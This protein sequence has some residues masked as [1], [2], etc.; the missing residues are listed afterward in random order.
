MRIAKYLFLLFLLI[1]MAICV[2]ILTQSPNF[3]ITQSQIIPNSK[4][5]TF[6]YVNNFYTW[7]NWYESTETATVDSTKIEWNALKSIEKTESF[8][9]DSITYKIKDENFTGIYTFS[10]KT[11]DNNET[12]VIWKVLG[13]MSTKWKF[14]TFLHGGIDNLL[15]PEMS[16]SLTNLMASLNK[17]FNLHTITTDGIV[18]HNETYYISVQDTTS[19]SEFDKTRTQHIEK[20]TERLHLYH[21]DKSNAPFVIFKTWNTQ[22]QQTIYETC[23]PVST[24][25]S[26]AKMLNV[27]YLPK[28][29]AVK[30]TLK[31]NYNYRKKAW[32]STF[33]NLKNS[34]HKEFYEGKYIEIY[35]NSDK[36]TP[37]NN[38]TEIYIPVYFQERK[39]A[40]AN[41]TNIIE[42]TEKRSYKKMA[43]D[44]IQR[45][46]TNEELS[47][48]VNDSL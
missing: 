47:K 48:I 43:T 32:D 19:F 38:V 26:I 1:A 27:K 14:W 7:H 17:N 45:N 36:K 22:T 3:R 6:N 24:T 40:I 12:E 23:L 4:V 2:F 9:S 34:N 46:F 25:D 41:T 28:F 11:I 30:T 44:T 29:L 15:Q 16:S 35:K 42:T 13:N 8:A 20:L 33:E 21:L 10:F 5:Q 18:N 31:G 39:T 37:S